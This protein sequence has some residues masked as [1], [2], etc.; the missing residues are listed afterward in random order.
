M[1]AFYLTI[2]VLSCIFLIAGGNA[3]DRDPKEV[4]KEWIEKN[5]FKLYKTDSDHFDKNFSKGG[6]FGKK[7]KPRKDGVADIRRVRSSA[8]A[9]PRRNPLCTLF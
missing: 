6:F 8:H 2:V 7:W 3:I 9:Y 1:I 4:S 5:A